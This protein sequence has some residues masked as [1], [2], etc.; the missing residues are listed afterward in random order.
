MANSH[1]LPL[2][3]VEEALYLPSRSNWPATWLPKR[4]NLH[5]K[6]QVNG[7]D[8]SYTPSLQL[9]KTSN[10]LQWIDY[11]ADSIQ[12]IICENLQGKEQCYKGK[13][14][15]WIRD[16]PS[17]RNFDEREKNTFTKWL[18]TFSNQTISLT[19]LPFN[20]TIVDKGDIQFPARVAEQNVVQKTIHYT[21]N[22]DRGTT[23]H[24]DTKCRRIY[25]WLAYTS[26][27]KVTTTVS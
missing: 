1:H 12:V 27:P 3:Q 5:L 4:C 26:D 18:N 16:P 17:S 11:L 6:M 8:H 9:D 22:L 23:I 15:C 19:Q 14:C 20:Q 24:I 25:L 21:R 7:P 13:G 2:L 10:H